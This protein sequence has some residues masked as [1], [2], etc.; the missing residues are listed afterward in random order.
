M[1]RLTLEQASA[2]FTEK[3]SQSGELG[4]MGSE[5]IPGGYSRNSL[6]F[7]PHAI[8]VDQGDAQ[9]INSIDGHR[10]LDFHNNYSCSITGHAKG[11]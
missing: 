6:T 4:E 1:A 8:F 10:L 9:Y 3:F 2:T 7:G 11:C 5:Y